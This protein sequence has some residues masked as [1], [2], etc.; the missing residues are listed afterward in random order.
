MIEALVIS[1]IVS[2]LAIIAL[3]LLVVALSRQIGLLHE[4]LR[5]VGALSIGQALKVGDP[6]P[7]LQSPGLNGGMVNVGGAASDGRSTLLFFLSPDCPVCK[8]L[9]PVLVAIARQERA[10]LRVVLA[11]DGN[12]ADHL[13]MIRAFELEDFPYVLSAEIG[14]A[15]QVAKLPYGYLLRGDG[16]I[17]AHGLINNR[18]HL[19]SLF[20]ADDISNKEI[21]HAGQ[22]AG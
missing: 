19:E 3:G 12:E 6:A 10:W 15:Y 5:P 9:L 7:R 8:T 20:E 22:M 16:D 11:S 17:A 4:R 1:N 2:W 21:V 18:E 14:M 13:A